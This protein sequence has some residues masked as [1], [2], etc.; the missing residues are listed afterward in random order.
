MTEVPLILRSLKQTSEK[1][2]QF[3]L[4]SIVQLNKDDLKELM[5]LNGLCVVFQSF[6]K[7]YTPSEDERE[8]LHEKFILLMNSCMSCL[9]VFDT[10]RFNPTDE[11]RLF[12]FDFRSVFEIF[13]AYQHHEF[14]LHSNAVNYRLVMSR[15]IAFLQAQGVFIDR[16]RIFI[17][18][19]YSFSNHNILSFINSDKKL[20]K[21]T[22]MYI[23]KEQ[24][25]E[26]LSF[27][28]E[29]LLLFEWDADKFTN[30]FTLGFFEFLLLDPIR[31]ISLLT[32]LLENTVLI[33]LL[34][35]NLCYFQRFCVD[36]TLIITYFTA[37][38]SID[39]VNDVLVIEVKDML[40]RFCSTLLND[41]LSAENMKKDHWLEKINSL[42][43]LIDV[44]IEADVFN[45]SISNVFLE[46]CVFYELYQDEMRKAQQKRITEKQKRL[47]LKKYST[48]IF[49]DKCNLKSISSQIVNHF[50]NYKDQLKRFTQLCFMDPSRA[51]V[52]L[53]MYDT[54]RL[55]SCSITHLQLSQK[56]L[57]A[58]LAACGLTLLD[59]GFID[60][61]IHSNVNVFYDLEMTSFQKWSD[62]VLRMI[63][64]SVT[65]TTI[66]SAARVVFLSPFVT[67]EYINALTLLAEFNNFKRQIVRSVRILRMICK[68]LEENSDVNGN[69][70]RLFDKL[71]L[72]YSIYKTSYVVMPNAKHLHEL[73]DL[74]P[75]TTATLEFFAESGSGSG[76]KLLM[77]KTV[78]RFVELLKKKDINQKFLMSMLHFL[79]Y[80]FSRLDSSTIVALLNKSYSMESTVL[81]KR[82]IRAGG[83]HS[84]TNMA[85]MLKLQNK[86]PK[87]TPIFVTLLKSVLP[88]FLRVPTP[89]Q[90]MTEGKSKFKQVVN[91]TLFCNS[92]MARATKRLRFRASQS[93]VLSLASDTSEPEVPLTE[94]PSQFK[95]TKS[96]IIRNRGGSTALNYRKISNLNSCSVESTLLDTDRST[97]LLTEARRLIAVKSVGTKEIIDVHDEDMAE[98]Q[99]WV[100][101]AMSTER[102]SVVWKMLV[103][104]CE[105]MLSADYSQIYHFLVALFETNFIDD[106]LHSYLNNFICVF[107]SALDSETFN[108]IVAKP[109]FNSLTYPL[110]VAC[111]LLFFFKDISF[112]N[113]IK[114]S[115]I[116]FHV[117]NF[118]YVFSKLVT[119]L[120]NPI[121][122]LCVRAFKESKTIPYYLQFTCILLFKMLNMFSTQDISR[123]CIIGLISNKFIDF[124]RFFDSVK[125]AKVMVPLPKCIVLETNDVL[126]VSRKSTCYEVWNELRSQS[127]QLVKFVCSDYRV[128]KQFIVE[129]GAI[130]TVLLESYAFFVEGDIDKDAL[131]EMVNTVVFFVKQDPTFKNRA[132]ALL[133]TVSQSHNDSNNRNIDLLSGYL[134]RYLR[135]HPVLQ[136]EFF[137][138]EKRKETL[139]ELDKSRKLY[140][141]ATRGISNVGISDIRRIERQRIK[142]LTL[143]VQEVDLPRLR[144]DDIPTAFDDSYPRRPKTADASLSVFNKIERPD[145]PDMSYKYGNRILE[146]KLSATLDSLS[147]TS[148]RYDKSAVSV[149]LFPPRPQTSM[150]FSQQKVPFKKEVVTLDNGLTMGTLPGH[151]TSRASSRTRSKKK[152]MSVNDIL[153]SRSSRNRKRR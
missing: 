72:E 3:A 24:N 17:L 116:D 140:M 83:M 153:E 29:N 122:N 130:E 138:E 115:S 26:S 102:V 8:Q 27:L 103:L 111:Y 86:A 37:L 129:D 77:E 73:I 123:N 134:R 31:N 14:H 68:R 133:A 56:G 59:D 54:K 79:V 81:D 136:D 118:F 21:D 128:F 63:S 36:S 1:N 124:I 51:I 149:S 132:L 100:L 47:L 65:H 61:D 58:V 90:P 105:K 70:F 92:V 57:K 48:V 141:A 139:K 23:T 38:F 75:A 40:N 106:T 67:P 110:I 146:Q 18:P 69:V 7:Y 150:G 43:A 93:S 66:N 19:E 10:R 87:P 35:Q 91:A 84:V 11:P 96:W 127:L 30:V 6:E 89:H 120:I 85:G 114:T 78:E 82:N 98:D 80:V 52:L 97:E 148:R 143:D 119:D 131:G 15:I 144:I 107:D 88:D 152:R 121:L 45:G 55:L 34:L 20:S 12:E 39:G 60:I 28:I 95:R 42:I 109:L 62:V 113:M 41:A 44:L 117:N 22:Q 71:N 104:C 76:A 147:S 32:S 137:D 101:T 2:L 16:E 49:F 53:A 4:S 99:F 112:R 125:P 151:S 74:L 135:Q 126:N 108:T 33:S 46:K 9:S 145:T 13:I 5:G 50:L 64:K 94:L 142:P 25:S